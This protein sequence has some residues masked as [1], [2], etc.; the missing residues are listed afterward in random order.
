MTFLLLSAVALA[1]AAPAAA[2]SVPQAQTHSG[3]AL[4]GNHGP[5]G[6]DHSKHAES[7]P[8]QPK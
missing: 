2:Q 4:D 8:K 6:R 5:A 3:Q 1:S 7:G